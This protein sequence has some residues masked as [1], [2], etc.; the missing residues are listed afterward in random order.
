MSPQRK[1]LVR[2]LVIGISRCRH[3]NLSARCRS[4][5]SPVQAATA[6][7]ARST[8]STTGCWS[9]RSRC[10]CWSWRSR[11]TA[12]SASACVPAVRPVTARRSTATPGSRSSGSRFPFLIVTALAVYA[13]V[14]LAQIEKK[15]PNEL[16]VR[17][18]GQQF[19]W[20]FEY[21]LPAAR[22]SARTRSTC[23]TTGR[24]HEDQRLGRAAFV[25]GPA[26]RIKMD[27]V[28]GQTDHVRFTP[29]RIGHYEVVCAELC[30]PGHSTM[31]V[32]SNVVSPQRSSSGSS[33]DQS[34]E[35]GSRRRGCCRRPGSHGRAGQDDLHRR[36]RLRRLPHAGGRRNDRK[37]R[38]EPDQGPHRPEGR[39]LHQAVDRGPERR[40]H[41]GLPE[42]RH[43]PDFKTSSARRRSTRS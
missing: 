35:A 38:P 34:R 2:M 17:A 26:F 14:V 11:S 23:R 30:G 18:I 8:R 25:L 3:R 37:R 15:Q 40:D 29:D 43:A 4:T 41:G 7:R 32:A 5:G 1:D 33:E 13:A 6:A 27:A 16:Q 21:T 24:L 9:R 10:S 20:H 31:R 36:G 12:S 39:G 19:T 22:S 42:G 28:P